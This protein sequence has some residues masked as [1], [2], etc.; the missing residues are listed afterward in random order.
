MQRLVRSDVIS[1]L[2]RAWMTRIRHADGWM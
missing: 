2:Q 1:N